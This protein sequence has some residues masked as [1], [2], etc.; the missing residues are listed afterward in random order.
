VNVEAEVREF[1]KAARLIM[2]AAK[3]RGERLAA[4]MSLANKAR[5]SRAG[6]L[7]QMAIW[8]ESMAFIRREPPPT[9]VQVSDPVEDAVRGLL[10]QG[11]GRCPRCLAPLTSER[12]LDRARQRR[13]DEVERRRLF[14][15]AGR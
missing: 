7:A 4:L 5:Q 1:R 15:E 8:V 2:A 10:R 11:Y 9:P 3:P 12:E 6:T 14:E 13:A